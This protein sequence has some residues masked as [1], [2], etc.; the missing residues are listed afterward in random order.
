M[1][2]F[3]GQSSRKSNSRRAAKPDCPLA[4]PTSLSD[5][6]LLSLRYAAI[7]RPGQGRSH[8]YL[9]GANDGASGVGL[10]CELARYLPELNSEY[11][12]DLV[13]LDGEE[14]V[15]QAR[16]DPLFLGSTHFARQY[17]ADP[18]SARYSAGVLVDMVGDKDLTLFQEKN[19]WRYAQSITR[20]IWKVAADLEISEFIPRRKYEI[21]D[22]HL[23]LN[24]IARI[25]TCD[26]IDFD[27][28]KGRE[29]VYWHTR[30]DTP[31]K[32]SADSLAKVC[33]VL[34]A[35]LR[36]IRSQR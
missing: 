29:N 15:Y 31:D 35:W 12:V 36:I 13:C 34:V 30:Q 26:I 33:T 4:S 5:P 3:P 1:A 6:D 19:S 2:V 9:S 27:Y 17:V 14:F 10:L 32:C 16:R 18:E 21:R 22:D 7:S 8:G 28:P 20:Q 11:G 24:E 23:P 25:P